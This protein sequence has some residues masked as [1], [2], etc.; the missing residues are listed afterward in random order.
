MPNLCD[1]PAQ[2]IDFTATVL[3]G[4]TKSDAIDIHGC[5]IVGIVVPST[6]DGSNITFEAA[7]QIDGTYGPVRNTAGSSVTIT[8][9]AGDRVADLDATVFVAFRYW[10]LVCGTS[11]TGDTAFTIIAQPL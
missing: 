9:A 10:K 5:N 11:Q 2:H 8:C 4:Q 1:Y 3:N 7:S 6:F